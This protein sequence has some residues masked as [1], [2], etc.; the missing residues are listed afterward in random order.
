MPANIS[1]QN[2]YFHWLFFGKIM[3]RLLAFK[4]SI[5]ITKDLRLLEK[6][7]ILLISMRKH[8][9]NEIT[10][11]PKGPREIPQIHHTGSIYL[12]SATD[13]STSFLKLLF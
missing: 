7:L 3:P 12:V 10:F 6:M 13:L 4:L 2:H 9:N 11:P 1:A 8:A 5:H